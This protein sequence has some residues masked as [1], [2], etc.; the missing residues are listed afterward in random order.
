MPRKSPASDSNFTV[1]VSPRGASR[2]KDGHVWVYRSDIV[3]ANGVPPGSLVT[4]T[5]HRGQILGSALYSSFL[6]NRH[7]PDFARARRRLSGPAAPAHRRCHRLSRADR[8]RHQ[9][10]PRRLQRGRFPARP[11]RRSLQRHSLAANS[12]PG[13]GCGNRS[14]QANLRADRA[15]SP[16][17]HRRTRRPASPPTRRIA[18]VPLWLACRR[19]RVPRSSP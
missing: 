3:S 8:S 9:R 15:A 6:A 11:H 18:V 2:L 10:L 5:D 13:H 12:H 1:K 4:V 7:P 17:F 16:R 14:R 19:E